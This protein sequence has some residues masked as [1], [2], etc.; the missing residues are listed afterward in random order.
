MK[1]NKI[2][3]FLLMLS[4]FLLS[5]CGKK[6]EKLDS[7]KAN[8]DAFNEILAEKSNNINSIDVTSD[9]AVNDL[10]ENLDALEILF[11]N[12]A[13]LEVPSH[14]SSIEEL[15]DDAAKYMSEAVALYHKAYEGESYDDIAVEAALENYNRAMKRIEYISVILRGEIPEGE[16]VIVT[17][18]EDDEQ[19]DTQETEA[20]E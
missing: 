11:H 16:D 7:Y 18:V 2:L 20:A 5:G 12:L 4:V 17:T 8:M 13:E 19:E 14:F 3:F 1:N 10:L 6:D 9:T 15:A